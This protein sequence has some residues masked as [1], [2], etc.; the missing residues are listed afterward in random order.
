MDKKFNVYK[1]KLSNGMNVLVRPSDVIPQVV[2]QLWYNVGT[3]DEKET[4][5]GMA[6]LTEH[7]LFKGTKKFSETEIDLRTAVLGGYSNAF[8]SH[9]STCY[10]FKFPSNVWQE[11]LKMLSEC[12]NNARFDKDMVLSEL[13][14]VIQELK[15]YKDNYHESLI[16]RMLYS[17][18][19]NHPYQHPVI[20]YKENLIN[21]K[22]EDL[23]EFYKRNYHPGN[24]TLVVTGDVKKEEVF[25]ETEKYFGKI[26]AGAKKITPIYGLVT[27]LYKTSTILPRQIENRWSVYVYQIPGIADGRS[28][29]F[30]MLSYLV[31]NGRSSRLYERLVNEMKLATLVESFIYELFDKSL[32]LIYVQPVNEP[33]V[34]RI[35]DVIEEELE[36]IGKGDI[37]DWEFHVV[38]RKAEMEFYSILESIEDQ[39]EMMG[40]FF[41]ATGDHKYF[42]RCIEGIKKTKR[43]QLMEAAKSY[44]RPFHQHTGHIIPATPEE[45]LLWKNIQ[46]ESDSVDIKLLKKLKRTTPV[47]KNFSIKIADKP[48]PKFDWPVAKS[49]FLDNGLEVAYCHRPYVPKIS[50]VL[51]F[52]ADYLYDPAEFGGIS[53]FVSLMLLE[54]TKKKSAKEL[55]RYIESNGMSLTSA[56]GVISLEMLSEDIDKGLDILYELLTEPAFEKGSVE[57]IKQEMLMELTEYWDTPLMFIDSLARDAVYNGHPYAKNRLGYKSCIE[58]F[59]KETLKDF[60]PK[61]TSPEGAVIVVVGDLT[62]LDESKL[63]DMFE[64]KLGN[65]SGEKIPDLIFPKID[66]K[67]KKSINYKIN[68]D[69]VVLALAAPSIS[70]LDLDYDSLALLDFIFTGSGISSN[71]R[72]FRLRDQSGL[73]YSIGGSLVYGSGMAPG[74]MLI[75]T[76]VSQDKVD[77]AEK[78]I[79]KEMKI[80]KENGVSKEEVNFAARSLISATVRS[81]EDNESVARTFWFL[82][83]CGINLDLFDKR[84]A[85]LSILKLG[86]V[87]DVA[88]RYCR[89]N[90]LSTVRIGRIVG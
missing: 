29:V 22:R 51:G 4:E 16:E 30:N 56:S 38:K 39:G 90:T 62:N 36:K 15:L 86:A 6:H 88:R 21:M 55:G 53:T 68:R 10:L 66:Y 24:A 84:G 87:N 57:K 32:F 18:F 5:R 81:F 63:R 72:L 14:A 60:Y 52:K 33:A 58:G 37:K 79:K 19:Q 83:K 75:K 78:L 7:M 34:A 82:K 40:T 17:I 48:L 27:D 12:M 76:I 3:K 67:S 45:D 64:K 70:R 31:A 44:L 41:L 11:S 42:E 43:E 85:F 74:M 49:F 9:D 28:H 8:T 46:D 20:G 35:N 50:M 80:L 1:K 2:V 61:Y 59:T 65:W 23:L 77:I 26:P 25:S 73:F 89:E 71:S 13:Q 54:G 69:Q 47:E